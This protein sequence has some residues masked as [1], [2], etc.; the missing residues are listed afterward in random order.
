[1]GRFSI[2]LTDR[3]HQTITWPRDV[4]VF[5]ERWSWGA[6]GGPK[7]ASIRLVG[8]HP[9]L[10][11]VL[12]W[13]RFGIK[14]R[15][16]RGVPLWWGYVEDASVDMGSY[17][18]GMRIDRMYNRVSVA[19]TYLDADGIEARSTTDWVQDGF[20]AFNYGDRELRFSRS[21]VSE[22][23][24][25]DLAQALVNR[26]KDPVP[27]LGEGTG[28]RN[29]ARLICKGWWNVLGWRY[30]EW[31]IGWEGH[32]EGAG[33]QVLGVGGTS[34]LI[35]FMD[36]TDADRVHQLGSG[37]GF[38][39]GDKFIVSG[40]AGGNNALKTVRAV[41][42]VEAET[43][44]GTTI[45]FTGTDNIFDSASGFDDLQNGDWL[46]ISGSASNNGM[47]HIAEVVDDS[48]PISGTDYD[49]I[50][51][52][53]ENVTPEAA[54]NLVTIRRQGYVST[55]QKVNNEG[56]GPDITITAYGVK[57]AQKFSLTN[58]AENWQAMEV[59]LRLRKV[60]F[61]S[62][63]VRIAICQ[64]SAGSPGTEIDHSSLTSAQL[65]SNM[66]WVSFLFGTGALMTD[67]DEYWLVVQRLGSNELDDFYELG[68]DEDL[69][70]ANGN[71][72]L[73]DGSAWQDRP[74]NA[75]L[76]FQV[77]GREDN[78]LQI[79]RMLQ[80]A[81]LTSSQLFDAITKVD[82]SGRI[83]R[84]FRDGES[85]VAEEVT[86]LMD[87]GTSTGVR[88][89]SEVNDDRYVSVYPKPALDDIP[90][91]LRSDGVITDANGVPIEAGSK[92]AGHWLALEDADLPGSVASG[93]VVFVE[94]AEY[95]VG[96]N[97]WR[98]RSENIPDPFDYAALVQG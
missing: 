89:L 87:Q 64:D 32:V 41:V 65:P 4:E 27:Y 66:E 67:D 35:V 30:F 13:C 54:G 59:Q 7:E 92:V 58:F 60:G 48:D 83:S 9:A 79:E 55:F 82:S 57:V 49:H 26:Y 63:G 42:T 16:D 46:L 51:T 2:D 95:D 52:S 44:T 86:R 97:K 81:G 29:E 40:S 20:S 19:Y 12:E 96:R 43:I 10:M 15:S 56:P 74:T 22:D 69:G 1:M 28:S 39:A 5:P 23:D 61:P 6:V 31:G 76:M 68:V 50:N 38:R 93:F 88:Y 45:S 91:R 36:D 62:D 17:S 72:K 98:P 25:D 80:F 94:E 77:W 11:N 75:D 90:L 8:P 78:A 47:H 84:T 73:W 70:Y 53:P 24:A 21:D 85:L 33:T 18:L 14:I 3:Q 71:L 37:Q 34:N